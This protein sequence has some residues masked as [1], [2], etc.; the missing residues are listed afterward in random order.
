ML[1]ANREDPSPT[2]AEIFKLEREEGEQ[3][4]REEG[5]AEG[6]EKGRKEA[7]QYFAK[8][9]LITNNMSVEQIAELTE[10][11]VDEVEKIKNDSNII[12]NP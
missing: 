4:G 7:Q 12:K 9:L 8:K 11:T 5:R 1:Q 6:R 3:K 10:L 2:L